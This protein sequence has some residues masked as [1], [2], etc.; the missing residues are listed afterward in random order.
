ML[1]LSLIS[2]NG[3]TLMREAF[4]FFLSFDKE[5]K[6]AMRELRMG[7]AV[8]RECFPAFPKSPNLSY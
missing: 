7:Y 5:L 1:V 3:K 6:L 8:I 4:W 2:G